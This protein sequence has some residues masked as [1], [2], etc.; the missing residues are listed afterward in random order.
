MK[1]AAIAIA[2]LGTAFVGGSYAAS[3]GPS[4][5]ATAVPI[6]LPL[7]RAYRGEIGLEVDA[8][9]VGRRV[10]HVREH[11]S[12]IDRGTVL[13]FPKWLPGNHIDGQDW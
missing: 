4:E 3:P 1:P 2:I 6:P 9:D 8:S 13:L 11:V 7:D 5:T 12:G 10:V